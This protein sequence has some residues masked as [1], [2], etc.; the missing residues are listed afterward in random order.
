MLILK[1]LLCH[2]NKIKAC[3]K[4]Q[5]LICNFPF[6]KTIIQKFYFIKNPLNSNVPPVSPLKVEGQKEAEFVKT[7]SKMVVARALGV[8]TNLQL[9]DKTN[10]T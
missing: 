5:I 2:K 6:L 4:S 10:L 9:V 8:G 7:E 1:S 3:Q